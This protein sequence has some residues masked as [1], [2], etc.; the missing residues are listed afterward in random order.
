MQIE[1][2]IFLIGVPRSGTTIIFEVFSA[3]EHLG[4]FS[5]LFDRYPRFPCV[6]VLSRL[7]NF[8]WFR[9]H[10]KQEYQRTP[11]R[12]YQIL[13]EET[14]SVWEMYGRKEFPS[15]YLLNVQASE[16]EK[17]R[18]HKLIAKIL[19]YQGKK[20]F[21][22]KL[23]G[24]S[25]IGYLNSIFP[26]ALFIH[27]IR[28]GRAVVHSL[29][30]VDFWSEKGGLVKPFWDNGL[31]DKY[32]QEWEQSRRSP[33]ILAAVQWR[34][35]IELTRTESRILEGDRYMELRY[36]DFLQHPEDSVSKINKFC[37]LPP[38]ES[39]REYLLSKIG[40]KDMNEKYLGAFRPD[41]LVTLTATMKDL[42]LDLGYAL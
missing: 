42:L 15:D 30:N 14:Y 17:Q 32:I 10:K 3:H 31:S 12:P 25:R 33:L 23:T 9:G 21:A 39:Q 8:S 2:P 27:I 36:E 6:S 20:R 5:N 35:I 41:E 1:K 37:L 11:T 22:N 16:V 4:W 24:P 40:L 13:P 26:D 34:N 19:M 7:A 38:A 28:D 29:M 18:L